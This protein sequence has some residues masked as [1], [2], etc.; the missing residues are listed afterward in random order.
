MGVWFAH[1]VPHGAV[2]LAV[3]TF[4]GETTDMV[5]AIVSILVVVVGS[6]V[7][8]L[9]L[10]RRAVPKRRAPLLLGR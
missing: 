3:S 2:I 6:D 8:E 1:P 7:L 9:V 4:S 5:L 10:A